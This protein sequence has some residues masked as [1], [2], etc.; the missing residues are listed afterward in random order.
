MT[1]KI[2]QFPSLDDSEAAEGAYCTRL[3]IDSL[4]RW[5]LHQLNSGM[6]ANAI[7]AAIRRAATMLE[8]QPGIECQEGTNGSEETD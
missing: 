2:I 3:S 8:D 7:S 6:P 4:D 5:V 1:G